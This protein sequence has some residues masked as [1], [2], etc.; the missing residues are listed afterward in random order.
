M[1][2]S[3]RREEPDDFHEPTRSYEHCGLR[4]IPDPVSPYESS[5]RV[6]LPVLL[7]GSTEEEVLSSTHGPPVFTV[8]V[9]SDEEARTL[10]LRL[11]LSHKTHHRPLCQRA[12]PSRNIRRTLE[13][14]NPS[15]GGPWDYSDNLAVGTVKVLSRPTILGPRA[16]ASC[17]DSVLTLAMDLRPIPD[18][19]ALLIDGTILAVADLHIG[20]EEELTEAGVHI[21]PQADRMA[22]EVEALAAQYRATTLVVLGDV[23]HFV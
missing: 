16:K 19:A 21:P 10:D 20:I 13:D 4:D 9:P 8:D 6:P 1:I 18:H 7:V 12:R 2:N 5:V 15:G 11:A 22:K 14:V 3:V 23:K 17:R